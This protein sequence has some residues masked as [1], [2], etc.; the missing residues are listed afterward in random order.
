MYNAIIIDD[1]QP[2]LDVLKLLLERSGQINIVGSF[3]SAQKAVA[4]VQSLKPDVA[5]IDIEMPQM[6]GLELAEKIIES[7]CD[8]EIVFVTS[9]NQYALEAF[10]VN[11]IDYILKPL[12]YENVLRVISRL[13][14]IKPAPCSLPMGTDKGRIYCFDKFLVYGAGSN[15]TIKWR[16]SKTEELFALL[17][18]NIGKIISRLKI[19]Q[20][21]WPEFDEKKSTIYLHTTIYNLKKTLLLE[22]INFELVFING[23]YQLT[24]PD[25]YID[26]AEFK[27]IAKAELTASNSSIQGYE[28]A[29]NLYKGIYLSENEYTWAQDKGDEYRIIFQQLVSEMNKLYISKC[30]YANAERVLQCA[31]SIDP[32]DDGFNE[33][34]LSLFLY[35][36]DKAAFIKQY[37]KARTIYNDELGLDLNQNMCR[38]FDKVK[39]L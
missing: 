30:D 10:Q 14:K 25:V 39:E 22:K 24:L 38:L 5:F 28:S 17:V 6:T 8:I 12:S 37:N 36:K 4:E 29:Y 11:A 35:K 15:T 26:T 23:G 18:Q 20:A 7:S 19:I 32:V 2:A 34:L 3:R 31:L 33:M 9:H 1:E 16:T 21:L 27:T 13:K